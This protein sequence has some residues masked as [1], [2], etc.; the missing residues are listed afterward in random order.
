MLIDMKAYHV[1]PKV[2]DQLI[3]ALKVNFGGILISRG[4]KHYFMG[5]NI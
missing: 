4:N 5:M 2:V 1:N 3:I